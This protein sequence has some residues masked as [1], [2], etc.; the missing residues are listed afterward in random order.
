FH[1]V[2][3]LVGGPEREQRLA[4]PA[5][6][7]GEQHRGPSSTRRP[8]RWPLLVSARRAGP[9]PATHAADQWQPD[10]ALLDAQRAVNRLAR[11]RFDRKA[12]AQPRRAV[13][14]PPA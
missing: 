1:F 7:V 6:S 4:R 13:P 9:D 8:V 5:F 11:R 3:Q 14:A 10:A 2:Q 12:L